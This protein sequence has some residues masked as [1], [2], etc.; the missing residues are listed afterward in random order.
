M[1]VGLTGLERAFSKAFEGSIAVLTPYKAQLGLLRSM[2]GQRLRKSSLAHIDF[3]T[4]DGFQVTS[5]ST[6]F[7]DSSSYAGNNECCR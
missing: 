5:S 7:T 1:S 3:A 2:A 6:T 4:V